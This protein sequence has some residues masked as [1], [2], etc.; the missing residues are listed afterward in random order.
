MEVRVTPTPEQEAFIRDGIS[1]G[2]F[3]SAEEAARVALQHWEN[4]ERRRAELLVNIE[5]GEASLASGH[6]VVLDTPA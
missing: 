2:R 1:S 6:V 4:Y 5:A 3:E